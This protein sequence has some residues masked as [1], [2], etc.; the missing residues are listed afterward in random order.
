MGE[1][2]SVAEPTI[3]RNSAQRRERGGW[4]RW[5]ESRPA[6]SA[7][8]IGGRDRYK[9]PF[10][11]AVLSAAHVL[12]LPIF[13]ALWAIIPLAIWLEDRGPVFYT[14]RRIG[15]GGREFRLLKFRSM[16][17][18]AESSTGPVW[19]SED[20]PR[21]TRIGRLL[22]KRALDELPQVINMWKGDLSLV[23][24]RPERPE[25]VEEFGRQMPEFALRLQVRPGLTGLA[26]VYG[27]Y[28]SRPRYKLRFDTLYIR[29]MSPWLDIKLL[30]VSVLLTV[31]A[32]WHASDRRIRRP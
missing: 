32:R 31:R 28:A 5:G 14:Q 10:D 26:Q 6:T 29:N 1:G 15:K 25:L 17:R 21:I 12:L 8:N 27:R 24:P 13:L 11:L 9:R 19:A 2:H 20:D 18:Q 3:M 23:G 30:F 4:A 16:I 7:A 22:R